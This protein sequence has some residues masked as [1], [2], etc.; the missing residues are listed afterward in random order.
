MAVKTENKGSQTDVNL[1]TLT[2]RQVVLY[3]SDDCEF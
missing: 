2:L 3:P 1:Q